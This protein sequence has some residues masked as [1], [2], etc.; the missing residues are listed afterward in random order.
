MPSDNLN[1]ALD[2]LDTGLQSELY[3]PPAVVAS[4]GPPKATACWRC[5]HTKT[6]RPTGLC[7]DC[8]AWCAGESDEDPA[9]RVHPVVEV[10]NLMGDVPETRP[11]VAGIGRAIGNTLWS[12]MFAP[13]N[14]VT[15]A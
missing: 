13:V 4:T 11:T 14:G 5:H 9:H 2:A 12:H 7:E 3:G 1:R 6:T 10:S 15:D 8:R